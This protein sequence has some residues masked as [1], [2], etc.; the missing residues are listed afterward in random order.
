MRRPAG[1]P[2]Q[3]ATRRRINRQREAEDS[4]H[5]DPLIQQMMQQFGAVI[6]QDT[7]EPVEAPVPQAS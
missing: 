2:A 7:I 6:R 4:I 5:G 3:A 1:T